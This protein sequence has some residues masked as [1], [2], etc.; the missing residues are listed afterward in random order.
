MDIVVEN[1]TKKYG[2]QRA[3]DNI[4]FTVRT[5]E[6]L[7]F[8]GPNGAGKTT[9]MKAITTSF[10]PS[11]GDVRIGDISVT[12]N[13]EEVKTRIGYLPES[14]PLYTEMP[15]IDYLYY[16]AEIHGIPKKNREERILEM[17]DICG[18]EG[19]KHKLISELSKGYRQ[20]VGLAQALIHDP[21]VLILDEPTTGLDPNQI[22]EIRELIKRIGRE[23]TVILSSHILAEVEATCDRILIINKGKI[24]ADGTAEELRK[25]AQGN[26]ILHVGIEGPDKDQLFNALKE[27]P[28]VESVD[29]LDSKNGYIEIIAANG[30][31]SRKEV[32]NLCVKNN[33][34]LTA[35]IPIETK[36]EDVFRN[37]TMK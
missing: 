5:G 7:G 35:M 36:L 4:S 19:E 18:L 32:F 14:N 2:A 17:V 28:S 22:V 25:S 24:V 27:I 30:M 1:L 34:E 23:K 26:E 13:P 15:V 12:E 31:S 29:F 9:T 33:W 3:V 20:R 37:V 11:S 16:V 21:E 10:A 6:V 8:L